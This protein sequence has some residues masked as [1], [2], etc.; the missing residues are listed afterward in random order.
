MTFLDPAGRDFYTR[1]DWTAQATVATLRHAAGIDPD[2]PRLNALIGTLTERSAAFSTLWQAHTVRGKT[3]EAKQLNHPDVG[4]LTLTYQA[5]DVRDAPG[6]QLVIYHAEPGSPNAEAL[7]CSAPSTPSDG[8][9]HETRTHRTNDLALAQK[10]GV[11]QQFE[12][13]PHSREG[14]DSTNGRRPARTASAL[15]PSRW[16]TNGTPRCTSRTTSPTRRSARSRLPVRVVRALPRHHDG[17]RTAG[18]SLA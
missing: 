3:Q 10:V 5:F 11:R 14:L 13:V 2:N 9:Q 4:P 12:A 8:R 17:F 18:R 16:C 1:W 15:T 6:Q 7:S